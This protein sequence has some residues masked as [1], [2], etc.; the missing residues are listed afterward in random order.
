[1][2]ITEHFACI[3]EGGSPHWKF[4]KFDIGSCD[5]GSGSTVRSASWT[6]TATL[7]GRRCAAAAVAS[8]R[9]SREGHK[10]ILTRALNRRSVRVGE[11][12]SDDDDYPRTFSERAG[13]Y[14]TLSRTLE[15]SNCPLEFLLFS[16]LMTFYGREMLLRVERVE[17]REIQE[18]L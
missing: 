17:F 7:M 11:S 4:E 2:V 12:D 9:V 1:M 18:N 13:F 10:F 16:L 14:H 6:R 8:S 5:H 3:F 15:M